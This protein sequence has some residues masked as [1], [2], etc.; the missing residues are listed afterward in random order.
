M[1]LK[2]IEER[3]ICS[4]VESLDFYF[5]MFTSICSRRKDNYNAGLNICRYLC[6]E[7]VCEKRYEI[8]KGDIWHGNVCFKI[9]KLRGEETISCKPVIQG[10]KLLG[11]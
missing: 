6:C 9:T 5:N 7:I 3:S 2:P 10:K 8:N 4:S 11:I 1:K